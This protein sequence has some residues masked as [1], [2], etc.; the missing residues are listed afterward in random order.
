MHTIFPFVKE[1]VM[2]RHFPMANQTVR[3]PQPPSAKE[4]PDENRDSRFSRLTLNQEP[5][6]G[7]KQ[8]IDIFVFEMEKKGQ[9]MN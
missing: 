8:V 6:A 4:N 9:R 2:I 3:R 7:A 5:A 1:R